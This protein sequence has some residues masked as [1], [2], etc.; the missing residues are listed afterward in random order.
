MNATDVDLQISDEPKTYRDAKLIFFASLQGPSMLISIYILYQYCRHR[1]HRLR[2]NN[3]SI[4]GMI[5]ISFI[6][7]STELPITLNY[8]RLGRVQIRKPGFC[9]FWTWYSLSLLATNLLLMNWTAIERHI[10]IFHSNW[11]RTRS[12]KWKYHYIPS[13]VCVMYSPLFYF[14]CVILYQCENHFDYTLDLLVT[15]K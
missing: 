12:Q 5:L 2:L 8:L 4:I 15:V 3:D 6:Q 1:Q 13:I 9:L 11:L 14:A 7:T 10:F